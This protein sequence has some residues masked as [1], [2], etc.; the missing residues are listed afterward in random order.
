[1]PYETNDRFKADIVCNRRISIFVNRSGAC[2][3]ATVD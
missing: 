1:M 2:A 3:L